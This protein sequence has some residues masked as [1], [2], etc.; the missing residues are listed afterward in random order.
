MKIT[1]PEGEKA[2]I[3]SAVCKFLGINEEGSIER[4]TVSLGIDLIIIQEFTYDDGK[5]TASGLKEVLVALTGKDKKTATLL[6]GSAA[7]KEL[8]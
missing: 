1:V 3:V 4:G 8:V 7:D 2:I 6:G 5:K